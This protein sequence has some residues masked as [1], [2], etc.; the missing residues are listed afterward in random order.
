MI[1]DCVDDI[2]I[3][4]DDDVF[5]IEFG[6]VVVDGECVVVVDS[7][8]VDKVFKNL[9]VKFFLKV[10]FV[11]NFVVVDGNFVVD[12]VVCFVCKIKVFG[13][14]VI[15]LVV[16]LFKIV[17]F[18]FD[19]LVLFINFIVVFFILF[20]WVVC[21]ILIVVVFRVEG[22]FV[23]DCE[24][25]FFVCNV[26]WLF[27]GDFVIVINVLFNVEDM[28]LFV[29]VFGLDVVVCVGLILGI[30]VDVGEFVDKVIVFVFIVVGCFVE[31]DVL[32]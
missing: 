6:V 22:L 11:G 4:D 9:V 12:I 26:E 1:V 24:V 20:F 27:C 23:G 30:E 28:K 25:I 3:V 16:D 18:D 17:V 2:D 29:D 21:S 8:V 31:V 7:F 14:F 15:I 13:F 10:V 19:N 5:L 32:D